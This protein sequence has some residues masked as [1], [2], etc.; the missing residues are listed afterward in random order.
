MELVP[1]VSHGDET[2]YGLQPRQ[3]EAYLQTP[4]MRGRRAPT[5]IGYGGA[6]GGG[7][8]YL[9]RAVATAVAQ[10]WPGSRGI[11]FRRTRPE[12]RENHIIPFRSEVPEGTDGLFRWNAQDSVAE[13]HN[14]SRTLFAYLEHDDDVFRYH[15]TEFDLMVF[16]ESTH[17]SW[18]QVS[19]L[20]G[21]RLRATVD[22]SIP[23]ALFPSNP[24]NRGHIWYKRL[25]LDR[26]Y[27]PE[28]DERP[29]DYA[30]VQAKL[31]DNVVLVE[32]D[33]QYVRK[34]NKLPEPL[35][36]QLRDGDWSAG[37]GL[38]MPQ[39]DRALHLIQPFDVPGHWNRFGAYDWGYQHPWSFGSFAVDS[40]GVVYLEGSA[41]GRQMLEYEVIDRVKVSLPWRELTYSV[42]GR[43]CWHDHKAHGQT[44]ETTA[45]QFANEQIP[46]REAN[47]SRVTG[48]NNLRRYLDPGEHGRPRFFI[49]DTPE[50]R[51][52][53]ECL[54]SMVTDP[55]KPEDALKVDADEFGDGGD[56]PY[57]MVRY[58]LMS[59]PLAAVEP[60]A[61]DAVGK[62]FDR[63]YDQLLAQ[64][65]ERESSRG[66]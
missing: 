14:R 54:E 60:A 61:D 25:F 53:L 2:I 45:E 7:K 57:D 21:N 56:D 59:R 22:G 51:K 64:H 52:V 17:Y 20:T 31:Q 13:W 38:A 50:N 9:A 37:A 41:H 3:L 23:F 47:D 40:D 58:G 27:R 11:I 28:A 10:S 26:R 16:E 29:T 63:E 19:W 65:S 15:G 42:A 43:D 48:L 34:L 66:F 36:S 8:S 12:V 4:L 62:N 39:L 5:F 33:Q 24:G 6:A 30:F 49:F 18:F 46:L 55:D 1:V 32:R 44:G 35:R